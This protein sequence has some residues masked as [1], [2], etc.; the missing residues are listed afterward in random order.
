M[1]DQLA[2]DL[3]RLHEA[4]VTTLPATALAHAAAAVSLHRHRDRLDTVAALVQHDAPRA[5]GE[6]LGLVQDGVAATAL[7]CDAAGRALVQVARRYAEVDEHTAADFE[8]LL[9]DRAL[10]VPDGTFRAPPRATDPAFGDL[11]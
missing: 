10:R 5:V 9:R 8:A 4:G 3:F 2:A 1:T 7:A 6:L 11:P